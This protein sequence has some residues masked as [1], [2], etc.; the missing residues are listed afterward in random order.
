MS[1]WV[2]GW[3]GR[4]RFISAYDP[5]MVYVLGFELVSSQA[6][7]GGVFGILAP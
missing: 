5:Y 3:G 7:P 4:C 2:G 1:V 6:P